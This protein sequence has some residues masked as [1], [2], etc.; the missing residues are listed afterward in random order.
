[1]GTITSRYPSARDLQSVA[2]VSKLFSSIHVASG[3][4]REEHTAPKAPAHKH[5]SLNGAIRNKV[6]VQ[7]SPWCENGLVVLGRRPGPANL[8]LLLDDNGTLK[9]FLACRAQLDDTEAKPRGECE[10]FAKLRHALIGR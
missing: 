8:S 9:A 7:E 5:G 2:S 10:S 1:M 6:Q 3:D 4:D